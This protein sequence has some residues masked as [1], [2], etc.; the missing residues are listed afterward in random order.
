M[1]GQLLLDIDYEISAEC[2]TA[3]YLDTS[4]WGFYSLCSRPKEQGSEYRVP[5]QKSYLLH[6]LPKMLELTSKDKHSN[7]WITQAVFT[8][9]NRRKVNLAHMGCAFVDLDYYKLSALADKQPESVLEL[10]LTRCQ[11]WKVPY[12]S[13]VV[14]SGQGLQLKWFHEKLPKIALPRWE[15]LQN[16][17]NEL[18]LSLGADKGAK[19]ISRIL[20]VVQTVNQKNGYPVRVLWQQSEGYTQELYSFNELIESVREAHRSHVKRRLSQPDT[21][22]QRQ[23]EKK[24]LYPP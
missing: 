17:L 24:P 2:E 1:V 9:P 21:K 13:A 19:D 12:P 3:N 15:Y 6:T 20:R 18:F 5:F 8:K 4:R 16:W 14:D 11:Q 7:H 22:D 10:V 23:K